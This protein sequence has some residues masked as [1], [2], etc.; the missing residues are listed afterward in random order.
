[1]SNDNAPALSK[2]TSTKNTPI[3]GSSVKRQIDFQE[4]LIKEKEQAIV[5]AE[6][7]IT[8]FI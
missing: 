4:S 3:Q 8:S 7:I 1:M 5:A 2:K 6:N